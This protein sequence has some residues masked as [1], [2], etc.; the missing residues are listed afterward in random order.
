M[1][2]LAIRLI[3]EN[4]QT[5]SPFLDLGNCGLT[6][7]P[8]D[9]FD[10]TWLETLIVS[11]S[12]WDPSERTWID[13]QNK[14][15]RNSLTSISSAISSLKNLKELRI[16]GEY[17]DSWQISDYSFLEPLTQLQSL[18]L[19]Y[20][21]INDICF[22]EPLT[23]LQRLYLRDSQIS[24]IRLL[25]PLT[26]L[27][28]LYL[29]YNQI[30]E[31]SE[32]FVTGLSRLG[33]LYLHGNPIRNIPKE[34]FD[35]PYENVLQDVRDYFASLRKGA[36]RNDEVKL[37]VLGN[38]TAGKTSL[39]QFLQEGSYEPAQNSTH[40]ISLKR[41]PV[42]E[43]DPVLRVNIW[44]FGG[45]EYYHA[46][47]RL[48]L[49]DHAVYLVVWEAETNEQAEIE[50]DIYLAGQPYRLMLDHFPYSYWLESIRYYA[51]DSTV[52]LVQTKTDK[53]TPLPVPDVYFKP[54][55]NVLS[56]AYGLSVKQAIECI[57]N[58]NKAPWLAYRTFQARLI[59][60]LQHDAAR[61]ALG[62][63]WVEIRDEVRK[64]PSANRW[65]SYSD[66]EN[67]CRHID[68]TIEMAGLLTYLG[69]AASTI[70]YVN[71]SPLLADKV[72]LNPQWVSD[73]VY[74]ILS[75][76]I[77]ETNKGEFTRTHVEQVLT[78]K[79]MAALT[80][81]F[82]E[83]MKAHRFE[84]I[85]EKPNT[86]DTYIAPQYLPANYPDANGLRMLTPKPEES[87]GFTL[88]YPRFMPKS[89]FLRFMVRYGNLA[90]DVY[91]KYGLVLDKQGVRIVAECHFTSRRI[92]VTLENKPAARRLARELFDALWQLS[93]Q[94][95]EIE[96]SVNGTGFVEIGALQDSL[97]HVPKIKSKQGSWLSVS[98]FSF[99]FD[100]DIPALETPP[101]VMPEPEKKKPEIFFSYA[102]GDDRE[103]GESREKIVDALYESLKSNGY[104]V[105]RDKMDLGY[106]GL[107]SEFMDR[108]GKGDIIVVALSDKYLKSSYC[109]FDLYEAFRN[110]RLEKAAFVERIYP[111]QVERLD[112]SP[113]GRTQYREHWKQQKAEWDEYVRNYAEDISAKEKAEHERIK[114]IAANLGDLFEILNDINA[115]TMQLL[116][117]NDFAEIKKAIDE[118]MQSLT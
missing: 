82:L 64:L 79:G 89:V 29:S 17:A 57:E 62:A 46:T 12:Y 49:D 55:Y 107:I 91:W 68:P 61:Y 90:Q 84:L 50:T 86:P 25:E 19:S 21:Q 38:T 112:F 75:Y 14:G 26:Q 9:L 101:I 51:P 81:T 16:G 74:A 117:E 106:K 39:T 44:D 30:S 105:K 102:W 24:D 37:I 108:I 8:D 94:K 100:K 85:F 95:P 11:N 5:R 3:K 115:L 118:R 22:L 36:V 10:C 41:W 116:S 34:I 83:L 69:G 60:T 33:E 20:N 66:F 88:H 32:Q 31:I 45:Q 35:K 77:Q 47:H 18:D 6:T 114:S 28:A 27:Q 80:D 48:F 96:V 73:T 87:I 76:D 13:S 111:I 63:K 42:S 65:M 15:R 99:L 104:K 43:T 54:P 53:H 23:Q 1:S 4:K 98:D 97:G 52:L 40:G 92:S 56:P 70:L 59:E 109:M 71:N 110:S 2:D 93:D 7:L 103:T 113:K 67:F 72:F 58:Y 78:E